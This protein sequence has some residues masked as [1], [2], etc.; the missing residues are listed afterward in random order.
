MAAAVDAS[1]VV[2]VSVVTISIRRK[3]VNACSMICATK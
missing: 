1:A 3:C 2:V